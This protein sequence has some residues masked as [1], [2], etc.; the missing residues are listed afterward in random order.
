MINAIR[1]VQAHC[2]EVDLLCAPGAPRAEAEQ[3]RSQV[4]SGHSCNPFIHVCKCCKP[5]WVSLPLA[6]SVFLFQLTACTNG[7]LCLFSRVPVLG[8]ALKGNQKEHPPFGGPTLKKTHPWTIGGRSAFDPWFPP[9]NV[10]LSA[11]THFRTGRRTE[12]CF[13][14]TGMGFGA[15]QGFIAT[16]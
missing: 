6:M 7:K 9:E 16:K 14:T 5:K 1:A 13:D 3:R 4:A 15:M 11:K 2:H 12:R 10:L 8:W